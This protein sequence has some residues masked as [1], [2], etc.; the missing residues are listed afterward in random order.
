MKINRGRR[1]HPAV[2][3]KLLPERPDGPG[4][5]RRDSA[6]QSGVTK[7][8]PALVEVWK[9]LIAAGWSQAKVGRKYSVSQ[10]T[11]CRAVRGTR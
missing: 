6:V 4:R 8:D 10:M 2:A 7:N 1:A 9:G 5:R 11:V 3:R